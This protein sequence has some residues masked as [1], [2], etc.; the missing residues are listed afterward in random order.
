VVVTEKHSASI[1][2]AYLQ[3]SHQAANVILCGEKSR[4]LNSRISSD[5]SILQ[6][7][8]TETLADLLSQILIITAG[9]IAYDDKLFKLTIFMLAIVPAMALFAFFFGRAIRRYSKKAQSHVAESNTI[10]RQKPC[11]GFRM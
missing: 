5:I 4:E 9:Y 7:S 8:I 10:V 6:H 11:R 3:S 1:P 2:S